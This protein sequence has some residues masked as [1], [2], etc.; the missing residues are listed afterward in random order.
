[1]IGNLT[2][3]GVIPRGYR[4]TVS[5][6]PF[7]VYFAT[8]HAALGIKYG[9]IAAWVLARHAAVGVNAG[10]LA[11]IQG[12]RHIIVQDWYNLSAYLTITDV[13]FTA[14]TV[15]LN[16]NISDVLPFNTDELMFSIEALGVT[17]SLSDVTIGTHALSFTVPEEQWTVTIT[18]VPYRDGV[19]VGDEVSTSTSHFEYPAGD[20]N[21]ANVVLLAGFD[22]AEAVDESSYARTL[23]PAS[24]GVAYNADHAAVSTNYALAVNTDGST[25]GQI[26]AE[27][28]ADFQ[29]GTDSFTIECFFEPTRSGTNEYILSTYRLY[30]Y[31]TWFVQHNAAGKV[32]FGTYHYDTALRMTLTTTAALVIGERVHIAVSRDGATGTVY[33]FVNGVLA[34]SSTSTK[35]VG[36]TSSTSY[37]CIGGSN[38]GAACSGYI[39]EVRITKGVCRY[40]ANFTVPTMPYPRGA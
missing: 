16:A 29:F 26:V 39:D 4:N 6:G 15:S 20:T 25:T 11:A 31:L 18:A 14:T 22:N 35:S 21:W 13:A 9:E 27:T 12:I 19:Q 1:M 28:A 37:L 33:L 34:V 38:S 2:R 7:M 8:R 23:T 3:F 30:N 36:G 10:M 32:V 17:V 40:T 5:Y 24:A